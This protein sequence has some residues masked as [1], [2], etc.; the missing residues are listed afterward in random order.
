MEYLLHKGN[1]AI[2]MDRVY[3][4]IMEVFTI[5]FSRNDSHAIELAY[6]HNGVPQQ[7]ANMFFFFTLTLLVLMYPR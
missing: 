1:F 7:R 6:W 3:R 4:R 2:Y 5:Q